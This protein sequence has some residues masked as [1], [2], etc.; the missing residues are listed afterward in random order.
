MCP[1]LKG[2]KACLSSGRSRD[3]Y[4]N[5]HAVR[6]LRCAAKKKPKSAGKSLATV[7]T[8]NNMATKQCG[9]TLRNSDRSCCALVAHG[10]P[11]F[12]FYLSLSLNLVKCSGALVR[13]DPCC[14]NCCVFRCRRH[15]RRRV[16]HKTGIGHMDKGCMKSGV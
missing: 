7:K 4:R 16:C 13:A 5:N 14:L 2:R 3:R 8:N 15:P 10:W 11:F 9:R 12:F 6:R 1:S